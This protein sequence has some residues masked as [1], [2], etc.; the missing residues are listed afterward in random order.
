MQRGIIK[1][2]MAIAAVFALAATGCFNQKDEYIA[3]SV[4]GDAATAE[5]VTGEMA[6]QGGAQAPAA[7][8][9]FSLADGEQLLDYRVNKGDSL[10]ELAQRFHTKVSRIQSANAMTGDTIIAGQKIKI[11]TK[12]SEA[13]A[14]APAPAPPAMPA[15]VTPPPVLTPPAPSASA[16]PEIKPAAPVTAPS[17]NPSPAPAPAETP[18]PAPAPSLAAPETPSPSTNNTTFTPILTRPTT[19]APAAPAMTPEPAPAPAPSLSTTPSPVFSSSGDETP[20]PLGTEIDPGL[21]IRDN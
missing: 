7:P 4:T 1:V 10:W 20:M 14:P 8:E 5:S 21:K 12:L 16:T 2:S 11:P 3:P 13:P 19:P 6:S 17:I 9:P 18:E 15:P